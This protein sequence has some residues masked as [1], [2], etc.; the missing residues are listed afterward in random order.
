[1]PGRTKMFARLITRRLV[2]IRKKWRIEIFERNFRVEEF[3]APKFSVRN[4]RAG[5]C[6]EVFSLIFL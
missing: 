1:M 6:A 2:T 5:R 3:G 4:A